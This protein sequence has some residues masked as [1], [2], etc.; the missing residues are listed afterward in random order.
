MSFTQAGSPEH[1][2]KIPFADGLL[3]GLIG[4]PGPVGDAVVEN[5]PGALSK[6]A[7]LSSSVACNS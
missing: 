7:S 5:V 2:P 1:W 6:M 4:V 3:G